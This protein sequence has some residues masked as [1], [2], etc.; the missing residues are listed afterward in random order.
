MLICDHCKVTLNGSGQSFCQNCGWPLAIVPDVAVGMDGRSWPAAS[1]ALL[2]GE[3]VLAGSGAMPAEVSLCLAQIPLHAGQPQ[4][5]PCKICNHGTVTIIS[6]HLVAS[7]WQQE[8]F[9]ERIMRQ[10][11][12]PGSE[13]NIGIPFY[14]ARPG[15]YLLTRLSLNLSQESGVIEHWQTRDEICFTVSAGDHKTPAVY[16]VTMQDYA[17]LFGNIELAATGCTWQEM[18][19][20][21]ATPMAIAS[22]ATNRGGTMEHSRH[23]RQETLPRPCGSLTVCDNGGVKRFYLASGEIAWCGRSGNVEFPVASEQLPHDNYLRISG[24]HAKIFCQ[25]GVWY[26]E[27]RSRNGTEVNGVKLNVAERCS[28]RDGD[29]LIL[30]SGVNLHACI[31]GSATRH[32]LALRLSCH[33]RPESYL[34]FSQHILLGGTAQCALPLP[35]FDGQEVASLLYDA[36]YRLH[37]FCPFRHGENKGFPGQTV[38]LQTG[39]EIEIGRTTLQFNGF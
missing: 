3:Q 16:H 21:P 31:Y 11:L 32:D 5:I 18:L 37:L 13:I 8:E 7:F 29:V 6:L 34:A 39:D 15:H 17:Q 35:E 33:D 38:T 24:K 1:S 4:V 9:T 22:A 20:V 30:G 26:I 27:D 25:E 12:P 14:A 36:G 23:R 2:T 10:A 28:L 19:L